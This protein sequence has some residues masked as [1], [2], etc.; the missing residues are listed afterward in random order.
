MN[1]AELDIELPFAIGSETVIHLPSGLLGF[2]R[3]KKY[4]LIS[5]HGEEPFYWFQACEDP[6]LSFLVISPFEVLNTY[7]P[8]IS[9][10]DVRS[11]ELEGPDD[12]VL[13]NIVTLRPQGRSTLNLKGPIV[14]NRYS[15]I[16]K[17]VILANAAQFSVQHPLPISEQSVC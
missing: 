2:E 14:I 5:N 13:L 6:S 10:E 12:A 7:R 11:L 4:H 1:T 16:G 15:H 17:Q 3:V 8:D 9:P